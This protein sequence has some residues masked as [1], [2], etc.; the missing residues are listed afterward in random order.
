MQHNGSR[1]ERNQ[2]ERD[3]FLGALRG[4]GELL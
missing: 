2:D 3:T 4:F 1:V